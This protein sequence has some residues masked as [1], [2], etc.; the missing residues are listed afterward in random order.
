MWYRILAELEI[1]KIEV[2]QVRLHTSNVT[3][4]DYDSGKIMI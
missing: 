4:K 3:G 1:L 2:V